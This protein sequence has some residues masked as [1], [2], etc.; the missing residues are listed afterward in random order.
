MSEEH[1]F[2]V[3]IIG[4]LLSVLS[5]KKVF[6]KLFEMKESCGSEPQKGNKTQ[7]YDAV[8]DQTSDNK[9]E[10]N[11]RN[12]LVIDLESAQYEKTSV[13]QLQPF[14]KTSAGKDET[15]DEDSRL[16]LPVIVVTHHS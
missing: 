3:T 8:A 4:I 11:G 15:G 7:L 10:T 5:L 1:I 12:F 9:P 6:Q 14:E 16:D 13:I 2:L